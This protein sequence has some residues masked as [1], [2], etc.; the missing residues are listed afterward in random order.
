MV[1]FPL[2]ITNKKNIQW[3]NSER[4]SFVTSI[5]FYVYTSHLPLQNRHSS[6][7]YLLMLKGSMNNSAPSPFLL[8]CTP[9]ELP[10]Q[11]CINKFWLTLQLQFHAW[12]F[13]RSIQSKINNWKKENTFT[14]RFM[15]SHVHAI[16]PSLLNS[17]GLLKGVC[18]PLIRLLCYNTV[19]QC[20]GESLEIQSSSRALWV[21]ALKGHEHISV[22][23]HK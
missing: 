2:Q 18:N 21:Q 12:P 7:C 17:N 10:E 20:E 3:L 8:C 6:L 11:S 9:I 13:L 16:S 5:F 4:T 23:V 14:N 15:K 22:Y 19:Q 1:L